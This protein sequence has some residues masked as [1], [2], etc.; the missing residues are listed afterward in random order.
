MANSEVQ[1]MPEV[2]AL[3]KKTYSIKDFLNYY[4]NIWTMYLAARCVDVQTDM[5]LKALNPKEQVTLVLDNQLLKMTAAERLEQRKILVGDALEILAGIE[6]LLAIPDAEFN[7]KVLSP[8]ALAVAEDM[9]PKPAP[10][11]QPVAEAEKPAEAVAAEAQAEE[12]KPA[13]AITEPTKPVAG[14]DAN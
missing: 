3:V 11:E 10:V 9:L 2:D 12:A 13:E 4:K 1:T 5:A 6:I 7:E 8:A 14:E